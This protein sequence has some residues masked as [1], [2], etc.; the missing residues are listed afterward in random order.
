MCQSQLHVAFKRQKNCWLQGITPIALTEWLIRATRA[1]TRT[2]DVDASCHRAVAVS[3]NDLT[4]CR[5]EAFP[6]L[7]QQLIVG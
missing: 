7:L 2:E 3:R 6:F 5:S 4:G 1:E